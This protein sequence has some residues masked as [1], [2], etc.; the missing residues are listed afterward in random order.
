MP[1]GSVNDGVLIQ[2]LTS[3][4]FRDH[5]F[6]AVVATEVLEHIPDYMAALREV[7]RALRP[8]GKALFSFPWRGVLH[9]KNVQRAEVL[10]DGSIRHIEPPEYH[11]DPASP[12]GVL[13]YWHFGWTVL[14]DIRSAGF[15]DASA[16]FLFSP[17]NGHMSVL[18]PVVVA[19]R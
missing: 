10:P 8:G 13:C 11:E 4:S 15:S 2:D 16:S 1:S 18:S 5:E 3:L 6:D 19:L 9:R 7:A 17:L 12:E 14:D